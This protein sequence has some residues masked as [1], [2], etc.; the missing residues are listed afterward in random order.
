MICLVTADG[1]LKNSLR[2][3]HPLLGRYSSLASHADPDPTLNRI[4]YVQGFR[5][6]HSWNSDYFD[7]DLDPT[8]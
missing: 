2:C 4:R 5:T 7:E 3:F 1:P 8:F 6:F